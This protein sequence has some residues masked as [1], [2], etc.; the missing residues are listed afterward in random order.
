VRWS[1]M[2]GVLQEGGNRHLYYSLYS[3]PI[4][5]TVW[6]PDA[7]SL[8]RGGT[9][10]AE[11][12]L[13]LCTASSQTCPVC[14]LLVQHRFLHKSPFRFSDRNSAPIAGP[15]RRTETAT[16]Q[17]STRPLLASYRVVDNPNLPLPASPR[18]PHPTSSTAWSYSS[19]P[20]PLTQ[21]PWQ[22]QLPARYSAHR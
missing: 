15:R 5:P 18:P 7:F 13:G 6:A 1:T 16:P 9:F 17:P 19:V 21:Q 10:G 2:C 14:L 4:T 22:S 3:F 11:R 20:L 8:L 12:V